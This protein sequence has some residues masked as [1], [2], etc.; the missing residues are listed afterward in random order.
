MGDELV[1]FVV[2]LSLCD[3][4]GEREPSESRGRERSASGASGVADVLRDVRDVLTSS[5]HWLRRC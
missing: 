3:G 2:A 5:V 1:P 4:S